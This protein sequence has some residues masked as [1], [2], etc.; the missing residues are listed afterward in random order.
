[1]RTPAF[2]V[3][4]I[5][6]LIT[7]TSSAFAQIEADPNKDY[8]LSKNRGPWM[9]MVTTFLPTGEDGEVD[10]GK[11]PIQAAK[12]LVLEMRRDGMPAYH[13]EYEPSNEITVFRDSLDRENRMK[14]QRHVKIVCV[15]AGNYKTMKEAQASLAWVKRYNPKSLTEGVYFK[16]SKARPTI[17]SGAFITLNP[18]LSPME[19]Q[20]LQPIEPT[21]IALNNG[22]RFSLFDNKKK[23]TLVVARISGKNVVIKNNNPEETAN[24]FFKT[25]SLHEAGFSARELVETLRAKQDPQDRYNNIEAYVWHD[26][27]ESIVTVGSFDSPNDPKINMYLEL[28]GPK[29]ENG[30]PALGG[31][32]QFYSVPATKKSEPRLWLFD[33]TPVLIN[34][35]R[36]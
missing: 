30:K 18:M 21:L 17:L 35:P 28:F 20:A 7:A 13:F 9:I 31:T 24:N 23:Y 3:L 10:V 33:P 6:G 29:D 8:A 22:E 36:K 2:C 4:A 14:N 12:D 25:T 5:L 34:V 11:S 1:M 32:S 19:I 27:N 16:P 15:M 26:L